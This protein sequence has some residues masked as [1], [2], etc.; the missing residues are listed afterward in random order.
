ML[1][2]DH[3]VPHWA[4]LETQA[5]HPD[6]TIVCYLDDTYYLNEPL[7][8][9]AAL[10]TGEEQSELHSGVESNRTKQE[11]FGGAE[12]DLS[13]M[14][15]TLRGAPTAPPAPEKGY[16]GGKLLSIKVLGAFFG[17]RADCARRL[18]ARVEEH[19]AP[20]EGACRLRDNRK[21]NVSLQCAAW[22]QYSFSSASPS[23]G[24]CSCAHLT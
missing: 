15:A 22:Y 7:L 6:A 20:M 14:P 24:S 4:L 8:G 13:G 12:A 10:R 2:H 16:A 17:D 19:M 21:V 1:L 23:R 3:Q 5:R 11:V 18:V 9:L